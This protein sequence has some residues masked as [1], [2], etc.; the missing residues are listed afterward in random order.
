MSFLQEVLQATHGR[1]RTPDLRAFPIVKR[2]RITKKV[3]SVRYINEENFL[4]TLIL[5]NYMA[6]VFTA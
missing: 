2:K 3:L 6:S 5:A 1:A 4:P